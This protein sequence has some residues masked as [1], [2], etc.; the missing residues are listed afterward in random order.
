[1]M[2]CLISSFFFLP[3][4]FVLQNAHSIAFEEFLSNSVTVKKRKELF[5]LSLPIPLHSDEMTI[6]FRLAQTRSMLQDT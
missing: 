3:P 5:F 1:M 6:V 2:P 4:C